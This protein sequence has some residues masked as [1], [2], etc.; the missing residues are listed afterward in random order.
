MRSSRR[1]SGRRR[2]DEARRQL[3]AQLGFFGGRV[4]LE[5]IHNLVAW[6]EY[7]PWL[8]EERDRGSIGLIGATHWKAH[9]FDELARVMRTGRIQAIQIPFN[10]REREVEGEILPLAEELGL[11]VIAMRPL[12]G[13]GSVIPPPT[14]TTA[15]AGLAV[16]SWAE[17]LLLWA[18]SDPRI[19][20]V[21]PA[22]SNP[23][24]ASGNAA[25]GGSRVLDPD[26]RALVAR[27]SGC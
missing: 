6:Q 17:A 16:D 2:A 23:A 24:H 1:R 19:H 20:V 14:D 18:L 26:E 27:L 13:E 3:E 22:T 11:G 5:Q 7:L 25:A 4:E 8:E 9:A 15:V 21:I 10:P 12:G